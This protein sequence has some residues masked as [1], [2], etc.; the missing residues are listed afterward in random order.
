MNDFPRA[1]R[2]LREPLLHFLL[3]GFGL[4]LVYG[5]IAGPSSG[6]G[7]RIVITQGRIE[8]LTSRDL[9]RLEDKL[10]FFLALRM[11]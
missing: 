7:G 1:R 10:D 2:V 3:L 11:S 5:W 9:S 6:E 4:F 8:Q